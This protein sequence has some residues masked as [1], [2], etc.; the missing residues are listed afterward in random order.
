[1]F[2]VLAFRLRSDLSPT[3]CRFIFK[4]TLRCCWSI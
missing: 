3:S 1:L 2:Y 4:S